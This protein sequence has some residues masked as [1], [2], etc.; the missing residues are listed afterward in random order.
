MFSAITV[1]LFG[2]QA[3]QSQRSW[4]NITLSITMQWEKLWRLEYWELEKKMGKPIWRIYWQRSWLERSDGIS[5]GTLCGRTIGGDWCQGSTQI[6]CAYE[7]TSRVGHDADG[8]IRVYV[9]L[10]SRGCFAYELGKLAKPISRGPSKLWR[11]G[12]ILRTWRVSTWL[13]SSITLYGRISHFFRR[14]LF[15]V[16]FYLSILRF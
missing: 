14:S 15:T 6:A 16:Y 7:F 11:H 10:S 2:T 9:Y 1:E 8:L 13:W 12:R 5:V 4:R 3:S